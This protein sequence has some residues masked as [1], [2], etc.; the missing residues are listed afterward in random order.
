[1]ATPIH[2]ERAPRSSDSLGMPGPLDLFYISF[3]VIVVTVVT[4]IVRAVRL[5]KTSLMDASRHVNPADRG[6]ARRLIE[7]IRGRDVPCTRCGHQTSTCLGTDDRYKCDSCHFEFE[8]PAH[9]TC[10]GP[11]E[12]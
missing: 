11:A 3:A 2:M 1:M 6:V 7:E 9:M 12:Y 8:G 5:T 10:E 4:V